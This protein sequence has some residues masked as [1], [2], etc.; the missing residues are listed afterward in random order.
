MRRMYPRSASDEFAWPVTYVEE[1]AGYPCSAHLGWIFGLAA[2]FVGSR[3]FWRSIHLVVLHDDLPKQER[4]EQ[5]TSRRQTQVLRLRQSETE[6]H[7]LQHAREQDLLQHEAECVQ[8]GGDTSVNDLVLKAKDAL[9][10]QA[11]VLAQAALSTYTYDALRDPHQQFRLLRLE[12]KG[13]RVEA[14]VVWSTLAAVVSGRVTL[15]PVVHPSN[16]AGQDSEPSYDAESQARLEDVEQQGSVEEPGCQVDT[17]DV[18]VGSLHTFDLDDPLCPLFE[19]LSY[20]WCA[21][22]GSENDSIIL[23]EESNS[24]RLLISHNLYNCLTNV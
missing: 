2:E 6:N 5:A 14:S 23:V 17:E 7:V 4:E 19:A 22:A 10:T 8:S 3:V 9:Q 24:S 15:D 12:A 1:F 13:R 18:V 20:E 11:T 16:A 21:D